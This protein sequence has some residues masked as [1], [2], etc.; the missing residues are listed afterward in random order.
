MDDHDELMEVVQLINYMR[1][2]LMGR[3]TSVTGYTELLLKDVWGEVPLQQREVLEKQ[4]LHNARRAAWELQ[5]FE[6]YFAHRYRIKSELSMPVVLVDLLNKELSGSSE[7]GMGLQTTLNVPPDLPPVKSGFQELH[8]LFF[9]LFDRFLN[10]YRNNASVKSIAVSARQEGEWVAVTVRIEGTMDDYD[11]Q[12]PERIFSPGTP[13][14]VSQ[15]I[16]R[17]HG[18]DLKIGEISESGVTF[19][20]AL[21]VWTGEEAR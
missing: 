17:R 12:N 5:Y 13:A 9:D 20:F 8:W 11:V 18:S 3:L 10:S 15:M 6:A 16:V 1:F 19:E 2:D 7:R 21:P 4:V 14:S